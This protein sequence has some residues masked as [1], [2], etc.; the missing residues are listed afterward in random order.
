[1]S[2]P[3]PQID[4]AGRA[5][6]PPLLVAHS[7]FL[8]YDEKQSRKRKPYAPLAT[9]G[10]AALARAHG[11]RVEFF[12]AMLAPGVEAFERRLGEVRPE[13]VAILED[14]FNFLTKMCTL[15]M[16]RAALDMVRAAR[17]CGCKVVVNGSDASDHPET[18]LAAGA[19]AVIL[20]EAEG[21]FLDLVTT[22]SRDPEADLANVPGLMIPDPAVERN[23][24]VHV[25]RTP[26]RRRI[27]D[28]DSLPFPAWDL[29]DVEQYRAAW[30]NAHGRL[31]WSMVTSRGCPYGCNW[32]A[33]PIFGRRY[34]QRSAANVAAE[35]ALLREHVR[36]DHVWFADDI[37]GLTPQWIDEFAAEVTLRGARTPFMMQSRAN[38]MKPAAVAALRRAGA[39]EVWMGVESGSQKILDAMDKGTTI[40]EIRSATR[41]LK[42]QGI[43]ACWF[44]QLGYLGESR[45]DLDLTRSLILDERPDEIGVSVA[46][47]LPGTPFFEKVRSQ[48]NGRANW[49]DTDSL[50]ML[51][52]G[53]YTT[54][55]YRMVR[56]LLHAE[57]ESYRTGRKPLHRK[58]QDLWRLEAAHRNPTAIHG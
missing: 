19:D 31:S 29:V 57:V 8:C 51:F 21:A 39:E 12:D 24:R 27:E 53:T 38:L 10:A 34:A 37:F 44:I 18:F 20:D 32:C 45:Q 41:S 3:S 35:L 28:L 46:Y 36:P 7:Y 58:W 47:P 15:R 42:A 14:N 9:L 22:W 1:L 52:H 49:E 17:S 6:S 23:G 26:G 50:E 40:N 13:I 43:R 56:D 5:A 25:K 55:F 48:L 30:T 11:F 2:E 54:D 33:K 16:R 4:L